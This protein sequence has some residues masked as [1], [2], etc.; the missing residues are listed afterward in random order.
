[1]HVG[2]YT[3]RCRFKCRAFLPQFK[4]STLRCGFG[5]ALKRISCAL[6]SQ[7]CGSCLLS[8]SCAYA[9]LFEVKKAIPLESGHL[10]VA[11]R[12]H[13]Y[14]IVPPDE[15]KR[16]YEANDPFIFDLI[17]FGRANDY[18]PHILYAVREMGKSGLGKRTKNKGRFEIESVQQGDQTIFSGDN[19][20]TGYPLQ[21]LSLD[22]LTGSADGEITLTCLTPLRLKYVSRLQSALP[23]HIIIRAALRRVSTLEAVYGDGEPDLDYKGIAA[24]AAGIKAT[25]SDCRWVE[26]ERYSSR[27][28]SSM[29]FGGVQGR[30]VYRGDGLS[31]FLPLLRYCEVTHLGKQTSFGLGKIIVQDKVEV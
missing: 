26:I 22:M 31:E 5:H 1:M 8:G 12:P 29:M 20:N 18:L 24:R 3:F 30:A 17:L 27:Q 4:G 16:V 7:D 15:K 14:V 11:Q 9:F 13:P 25:D 2:S 21:Q 10:R 19:L 28:R 23:F 6:R